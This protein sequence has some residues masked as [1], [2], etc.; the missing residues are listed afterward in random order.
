MGPGQD[1]ACAIHEV[2]LWQSQ[3]KYK[4]E[5]ERKLESSRSLRGPELQ[6]HEPMQA[7]KNNTPCDEYKNEIPSW[8]RGSSFF[9]KAHQHVLTE[10][11][12][13]FFFR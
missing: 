7:M 9:Q 1:P 6:E 4:K 11:A 8:D 5:N 2:L 3:E 13:P 10:I 12:A